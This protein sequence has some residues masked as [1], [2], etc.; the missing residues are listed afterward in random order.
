MF[1]VER[2]WHSHLTDNL[3]LMQETTK[4]LGTIRC[5]FSNGH[6][7]DTLSAT[8]VCTWQAF[9]CLIFCLQ[10]IFCKIQCIV[11]EWVDFM[12]KIMQLFTAGNTPCIMLMG[13]GMNTSEMERGSLRSIVWKR[14]KNFSRF[15][16]TPLLN[17]VYPVHFH[18]NDNVN[19]YWRKHKFLQF[20]ASLKLTPSS[21]SS[22]HYRRPDIHPFLYLTAGVHAWGW[23]RD[24]QVPGKSDQLMQLIVPN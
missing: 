5:D 2:I 4:Y 21:V 16:Q 11:Y 22:S 14:W 15:G 18:F 10:P 9:S 12:Q 13:G 19:W 17:N 23:T 24:V 3:Q 1:S 20:K 8:M 7:H 6:V